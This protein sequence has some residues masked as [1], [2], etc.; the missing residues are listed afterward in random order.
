[1]RRSD[2]GPFGVVTLLLV[3]LV[4]VAALASLVAIGFGP[5]AVLAALLVSRGV[6]PVLCTAAFP[7]ARADGLGQA[8]AASVSR[9]AA[10]VS[11]ACVVV[12][13]ALGAAGLAEL[14]LGRAGSRRAR[15]G[16]GWIAVTGPGYYGGPFAGRSAGRSRLAVGGTVL[17][18]R[19]RSPWR[20]RC[21]SPAAA[22]AASAASP[23]TS[24]A[25]ASSSPSPPCSSSPPS[26]LT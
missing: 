12:V 10:A 14:A 8:V 6:L 21:C 17:R 13:A 7:A 25:P 20:P 16:F 22:S 26:L 11:L 3:L 5:A 19:P 4:Q 2:I 1:M 9:G 23:A 24:T 15:A 18:R